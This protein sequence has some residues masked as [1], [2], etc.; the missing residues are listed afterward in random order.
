MWRT[1]LPADWHCR[2]ECMECWRADV[3]AADARKAEGASIWALRIPSP[4]S[5]TG[6]E[7]WSHWSSFKSTL[8]TLLLLLLLLLLLWADWLSDW[9]IDWCTCGIA[10]ITSVA[11]DLQ[12]L[13]VN[14]IQVT[15]W[16]PI[17]R[18]QLC[19][20]TLATS[21]KSTETALVQQTP[22]Y[23]RIDLH[24]PSNNGTS[25]TNNMHTRDSMRPL[26][27]N[28]TGLSDRS[29]VMNKR[30]VKRKTLEPRFEQL[31]IENLKILILTSTT[32]RRRTTGKR[33]PGWAWF[34]YKI[35]FMIKKQ[36]MHKWQSE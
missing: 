32:V 13:L 24:L 6:N 2:G 15:V 5:P 18:S 34:D 14:C 8:R 25:N 26:C 29:S 35:K 9:L 10:G 30:Y 3:D 20:R 31:I 7:A 17:R 23:V 1:G 21:V 11:W 4:P 19:V 12:V 33:R 28:I 16:H 27:R 22:F 36:T